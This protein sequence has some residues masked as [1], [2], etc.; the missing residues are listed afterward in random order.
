MCSTVKVTYI[1]KTKI[2][3]LLIYRLGSLDRE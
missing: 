2:K 1:D 3:N